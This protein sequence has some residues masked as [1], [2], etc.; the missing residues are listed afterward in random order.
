M[1]IAV[2]QP[3]FFPYIGYYQLAAAVDKFVIFDDVAFIKKGWINRNFIL[4]NGEPWLFTVP[5]SAASQ[6]KLIKETLLDAQQFPAWREKFLK[7]LEQSYKKAP[8]YNEVALLVQNVLNA[9]NTTIAELAFESIRS[10]LRYLDVPIQFQSSSYYSNQHLKGE[11][12][13]IDICR[14]ENA[15]HY[16]N[17][18][19]GTA[20]YNRSN[21]AQASIALHFIQPDPGL[22]YSQGKHTSFVP[23][24]SMIDVL[25]FQS[26]EEVCALLNQHMST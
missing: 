17:L 2:M 6:N 3:Y 22:R 7:T 21:F 5:L 11:E 26:P 13:I 25:M 23:S 8:H 18:S 19:G 10:V 15:R 4:V 1:K 12:R 24:L 9:N 16:F 14:K 20:L